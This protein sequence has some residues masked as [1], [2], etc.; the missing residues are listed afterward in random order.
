MFDRSGGTV[1]IYNQGGKKMKTYTVR[2][3]REYTGLTRKQLFDYEKSIPPVDRVDNAGENHKGYKLYSQEGLDKLSMAAL[4][5]ELGA[6]PQR[7][8]DIFGAENYD[9]KKVI[10]DLIIEAKRERQRL[11]DIITVADHMKE[12]DLTSLSYNPF[13]ITDLHQIAEAI[14]RDL[15]SEETLILSEKMEDEKI[16]KKLLKIYK[17]IGNLKGM[18][19]DPSIANKK[20]KKLISFIEIDI[21]ISSWARI[22]SG[23]SIALSATEDYR[24]YVDSYI[25]DGS[26]EYISGVISDYQMNCLI[27]DGDKYWKELEALEGRDY[28]DPEVENAI[29]VFLKL[30]EKWFGFRTLTEASNIIQALQYTL[31]QDDEI[32]SETKELL[33]YL[34]SVLK[35]YEEKELGKTEK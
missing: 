16:R 7:I 18:D 23:L 31:S 11:N 6:G 21:G 34:F 26:A 8:N 9:R 10:N 29:K 20:V 19:S 4:F 15:K 2:E 28:K 12:F 1:L 14:R 25:G 32:D 27:E 33:G 30:L 24:D 3:I 13:Q 22:L 5:A 17:E 35:Y